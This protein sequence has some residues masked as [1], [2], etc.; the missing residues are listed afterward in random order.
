MP[1]PPTF[2][3]SLSRSLAGTLLEAQ[4]DGQ[5]QEPLARCSASLANSVDGSVIDLSETLALRGKNLRCKGSSGVIKQTLFCGRGEDAGAAPAAILVD[6]WGSAPRSVGTPGRAPPAQPI[7]VL[8]VLIK[9]SGPRADK[10]ASR[11]RLD[12][13]RR[14]VGCGR[15][16]GSSG[17]NAALGRLASRILPNR[18]FT[19]II[20][21]RSRLFVGQAVQLSRGWGWRSHAERET[22]GAT[23]VLGSLTTPL[24]LV[25]F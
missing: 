23:G 21:S 3:C 10:K 18:R 24:H 20:Y 8:A 5:N 7:G 2:I 12:I 11:P 25:S 13:A 19:L 17:V 9:I 16:R 4:P 6:R 15:G 1:I 22:L 14:S